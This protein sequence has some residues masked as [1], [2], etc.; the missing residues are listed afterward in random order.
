MDGSIRLRYAPSRP[1]VSRRGGIIK[2][3]LPVKSGNKFRDKRE[4]VGA[5]V[6]SSPA[7]SALVDYRVR[8]QILN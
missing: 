7:E 1:C 3:A 4:Y 5:N 6:I 2:T 8:K